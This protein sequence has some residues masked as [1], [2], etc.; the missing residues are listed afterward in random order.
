MND[1]LSKIENFLFDIL[2][3]VLPGVIFLTILILPISLVDIS[4]IPQ[5]EIDASFIL[6]ELSILSK[7]ITK[8]WNSNFNLTISLILIISYLIGHTI[9]V[10][11]IIKYEILTAVFDKSINKLAFWL[12]EKIKYVINYPYNLIFG[13][14]IYSTEFYKWIKQLFSPIKNLLIKIFVFKSPDYFSDNNALRT[15]CVDIINHRIGT[16][17]PDKW[18]SVYKFST[19]ITNQENIKSLASNFLAKY[20]LYR[21]LSFIFIFATIY[22]YLFLEVSDNYV[23]QDLKKISSLI[24]L[25]SILLWFTFHYKYKRYWTLCGN[26]TLV[27]LFYFLNKKKINES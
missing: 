25:A 19:V 14:D 27:S 17:Y 24:F 5:K 16:T 22:Y 13:S 6:A 23:S 12:F 4:K 9:K 18:Y 7:L 21:S 26:E 1:A 15:K 11:S 20:N 10:F 8:Y 3:L 2:G